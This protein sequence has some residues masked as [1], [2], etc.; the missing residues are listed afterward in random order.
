MGGNGHEE[1]KGVEAIKQNIEEAYLMRIAKIKKK[2]I[3][4]KRG[5][6]TSPDKIVNMHG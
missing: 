4:S 2:A 3:E 5:F 6:Q 1:V